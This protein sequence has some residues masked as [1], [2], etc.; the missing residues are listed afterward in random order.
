M[1]A[2]TESAHN[3]SVFL[4]L[5]KLM[6]PK[7]WVKNAF[8]VAPLIF[9]GQFL[10][11]NAVNQVLMA[12][13]LFCIASSATYIIN[14]MKDIEKDRLHPTKSKKRPLASGQVKIP[15]AI[16]L[17]VV[18]YGLLIAAFFVMPK[19]IMVISVY[20][21]INVAYTLWLKH[22]PVVDIFT[23]AIGFVI[24]VFAGAMALDVPV[25]SWMFVTTLCLALYLAAVKRR[26]ELTQSGKS[27][28]SVLQHYSVS[29]VD[30][31]AEMSATGA[32]LFYSLFVMTARTDLVITIPFV[33]FGLF[34]YWYVVEKLD[35]GESPTDALLSDWQLL[36]TV[37]LWGAACAWSIWPV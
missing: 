1:T 35:G 28:R 36:V 33:L 15:H 3:N 24:R 34:R 12:V 16:G 4:G 17:L 27:G 19:V 18:L 32:L 30:R 2:I 26:Q 10:D 7:Q 20:L 37:V 11:I 13:V 31:Y 22:Q 23:I 14:D 29:L 6:R 8:V 25:S 21:I 5:L 9:S